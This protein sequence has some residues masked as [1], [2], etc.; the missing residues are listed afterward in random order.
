MARRLDPK[1]QRII[2]DASRNTQSSD[3]PHPS[4]IPNDFTHSPSNSHLDRRQ[5]VVESNFMAVGFQPAHTALDDFGTYYPFPKLF[6][7]LMSDLI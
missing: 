5:S 6:I 7:L 2:E 3:T 4:V 1:L